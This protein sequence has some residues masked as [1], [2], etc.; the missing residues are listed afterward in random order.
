MYK[1]ELCNKSFLYKI[2]LERHK[3]NKKP[4]NMIDKYE[5]NDC[6]KCFKQKKNL[7]DH[8]EKEI[9]NNKIKLIF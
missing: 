7:L 4:C 6:N 1:C 2:Y 9:C 5:C 8:Q 3:N